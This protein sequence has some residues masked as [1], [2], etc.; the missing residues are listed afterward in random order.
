VTIATD[1]RQGLICQRNVQRDGRTYRK[2]DREQ[3]E[4]EV[5]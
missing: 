5:T 1:R 4:S 3:E 2:R